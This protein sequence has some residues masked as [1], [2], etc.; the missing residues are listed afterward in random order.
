MKAKFNLCVLELP[1][2]F[3]ISLGDLHKKL[4]VKQFVELS[5]SQEFG[6]GWVNPGDMF[7][8][9]FNHED[10][11]VD[12]SIICGFR[13]DKKSVPSALVKKLFKERIK[14]REKE[15]GQKLEK[16]D[17]QILKEECKEQLLLKA[18]ANPKMIPW[19]WN[20]E[21]NRIYID[22]KSDKIIE[23]FI[24]LF[25]KT[26]EV[27]VSLKNYG[28]P[29]EQVTLFLGWIWKQSETIEGQWV[30]QGIT[31][32]VDKNIFK[33]NGP[34][35]DAFMD[36]IESMKEGKRVKDIC[37]RCA[38]GG[39]DYYITFSSK[40]LIVSVQSVNKIKHESIATAVLDR[41]DSCERVTN[42][43]ETLIKDY[44]K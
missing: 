32:N 16:A 37:V 44:L 24:G 31:L 43:I 38:L 23:E 2:D 3:K 18:M 11:A 27:A 21:N 41:M 26:F 40:N 15:M 30:D 36:E 4:Q 8:A 22:L 39:N 5:P 20:L 19:L 42:K 29:E 33:F 7:K 25:S 6:C 12:E 1:A 34:T 35:L 14:E 17:R 10:I 13:Y 9:S 28:I